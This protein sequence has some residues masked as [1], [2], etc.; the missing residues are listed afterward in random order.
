MANFITPAFKS[1]HWDYY[2]QRQNNPVN[3]DLCTEIIKRNDSNGYGKFYPVIV[4]KGC[5]VIWYYG[6]NNYKE[7]DEEFKSIISVGSDKSK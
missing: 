6:E 7:R 3:I 2:G 4:F 5:N 1:V